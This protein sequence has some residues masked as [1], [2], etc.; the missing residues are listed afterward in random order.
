VHKIIELVLSP[1]KLSVQAMAI[2]RFALPQH[3]GDE[4]RVGFGNR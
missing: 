1:L 2:F 3:K 4:L